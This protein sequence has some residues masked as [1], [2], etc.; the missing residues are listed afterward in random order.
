MCHSFHVIN[1][2]NN[3]LNNQTIDKAVDGG[4]D[5][6]DRLTFPTGTSS[7]MEKVSCPTQTNRSTLTL[8]LTCQYLKLVLVIVRVLII[9]IFLRAQPNY[10]NISESSTKLF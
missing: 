2:S 4:G 7:L 5:V 3:G 10:F 8:T 1:Q 6:Y 9:L